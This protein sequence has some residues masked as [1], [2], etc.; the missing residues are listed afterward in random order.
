MITRLF[1]DRAL[2]AVQLVLT[3]V[4]LG[5]FLLGGKITRYTNE[6]QSFML[7]ARPRIEFAGRTL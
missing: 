5:I 6:G 2:E 3:T 7:Y 1:N 4:L